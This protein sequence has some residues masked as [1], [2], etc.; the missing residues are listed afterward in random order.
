MF[1]M[2]KPL[3]PDLTFFKNSR[4]IYLN[5]SALISAKYFKHNLAQTELFIFC[6]AILRLF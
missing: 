4:I 2:L 3:S 1:R 6:S 5:I